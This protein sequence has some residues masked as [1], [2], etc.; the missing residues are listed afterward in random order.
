M[1]Y[2]SKSICSTNLEFLEVILSNERVKS[3]TLHTNYRSRTK[4]DQLVRVFKIVQA[5][6]TLRVFK[7]SKLLPVI[8]EKTCQRIA[9]C[10]KN[11]LRILDIGCSGQLLHTRVQGCIFHF[12]QAVLRQVGRLGL[13]TDHVHNQENQEKS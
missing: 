10:L 2:K 13:K 3:C 6:V 9:S 5:V 7:E 1:L 4:Q 11:Y 8:Q 12:F